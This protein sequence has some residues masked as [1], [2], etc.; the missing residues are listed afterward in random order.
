MRCTMTNVVFG[1]PQNIKD[2]NKFMLWNEMMHFT[3]N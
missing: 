2:K 3:Q 1:N